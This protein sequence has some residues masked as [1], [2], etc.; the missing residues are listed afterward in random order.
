MPGMSNSK[1]SKKHVNNG[2][3]CIIKAS[4]GHSWS[5]IQMINYTRTF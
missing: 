3:L 5:I 2:N 1:M 4:V